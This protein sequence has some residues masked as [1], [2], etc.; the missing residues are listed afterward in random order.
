[1][2]PPPLRVDGVGD[3]GEVVKVVEESTE[4]RVL[5]LEKFPHIGGRLRLVHRDRGQGQPAGPISAVESHQGGE[6]L[7]AGFTPSGPEV[8]EQH[9]TALLLPQL[10]PA[11]FVEFD[12]GGEWDDGA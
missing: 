10:P 11:R 1:M 5:G 8:Y 7:A 12:D 9:A 6:F 2:P 3:R 4:L